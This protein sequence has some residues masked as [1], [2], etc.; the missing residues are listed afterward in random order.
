M[1]VMDG[2]VSII[3][4]AGTGIG[5]VAAVMFA[6][7]GSNLVLAGRRQAPL[8]EVADL[9]REHGV[10]V[11]VRPTD[12]ENGDAAADLGKWSLERFGKVDI[13]V[14]NAGHSSRVRSLRYVGLRSGN[15]C[16]R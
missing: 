9:A 16:L 11:E 15:R 14:N 6:E 4:G 13:L 3:T 7:A 2:K 10:E 1:G 12:L 5:K 8:D